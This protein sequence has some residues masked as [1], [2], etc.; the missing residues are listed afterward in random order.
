VISH[1]FSDRQRQ[2]GLAHATGTRQGQQRNG[3]LQET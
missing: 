2:P 3:F 1:I